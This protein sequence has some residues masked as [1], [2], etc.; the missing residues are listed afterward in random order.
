VSSLTSGPATVLAQSGGAQA[1]L[2]I[3]F[4]ATT[5]ASVVLQANP[6]SIPPNTAGSTA[7]SVSLQAIVRDAAG[8]PVA[9]RVVNFTAVADGSNGVIT[10]GSG[11]TDANGTVV[12]QFIPG[13]LTTASNGVVLSATVQGTS[14]TGTASLTVSGQALFISIGTGNEIENLN[15][16][17]YQKRFSV[18]VT[19]AN[20]APAA[21][22][23]V[24]LAVFPDFYYKGFMTK[25]DD[26][27]VATRTAKC[28]NEDINRNGILNPGEDTNGDGLLTPGLPVV[29]SPAS[30][31]TDATGFAT[32]FL[33]YGENYAPWVDTTITAR[34]TVGGTESVKT[35]L[36]T[37]LGAAEDFT[38]DN[39]PA[40]VINPFGSDASCTDPN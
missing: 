32:F 9:G 13:A 23:I 17:T 20:G 5:P 16:T 3:S 18:Y 27:W 24:N 26:G 36:Y 2:A 6:G 40:G 10:P 25:G 28:A 8:N 12:V 4:I 37:L 30:V 35:Q 38:G 39:P 1:T 19:D 14:V 29:V 7:N 22:R 11:T 21:N 31:T 15:Q 34:T 33:Q